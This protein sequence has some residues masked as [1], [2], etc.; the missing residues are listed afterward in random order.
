[1][2]SAERLVIAAAADAAYALPLAVTLR[3]A[4]ERLGDGFRLEVHAVDDGLGAEGRERVA[5]SLAERADL[6]W[7]PPWPLDRALP[8]WNH[9]AA[10]TYQKLM[11]GSW[12]P[13]E[14]SRALWLDGDLLVRAD[15]AALW[16]TP[17]DGAVAAAARDRLVPTFGSRF[18][19]G[20]RAELG[21]PDEAPYFNAG[22]LLVDLDRWRAES[23]GARALDYLAR[24]G[25]RI[26]FWDQE[27]LNAALH[28]R[29]RELDPR[30]NRHAVLERL[31]A[32]TPA[33]AAAAEEAWI[34]H[35]CGRLKPW[36]YPGIDVHQAEY[37]RCLDATAWRGHRPPAGALR[38]LA[39]SYATSRWRRSL[40]GAEQRAVALRHAL[41][42]LRPSG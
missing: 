39:A 32:R 17:L 29:W 4:V 31:F 20:G 40:F 5:R 3:S 19:V 18:G 14:S 35:Y 21:L 34:V 28:D 15:L 24:R 33:D 30:W 27:A 36:L 13:A 26:W 23:V 16:R 25:R 12:L 1:M 42:R 11:L 6:V 2:S 22:V 7:H 37:F 10:T 8:L 41:E 38:R 9:M